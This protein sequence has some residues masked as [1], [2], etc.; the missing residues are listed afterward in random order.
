MTW[1]FCFANF[2][3]IFLAV[4]VFIELFVIG[5]NESANELKVTHLL[6]QTSLNLDSWHEDRYA[7]D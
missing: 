3:F 5:K 4:E 2:M 7:P 6:P 1:P